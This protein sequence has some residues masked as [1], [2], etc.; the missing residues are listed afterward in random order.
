MSK[1]LHFNACPIIA[2]ARAAGEMYYYN[3]NPCK[4]GHLSKRVTSTQMCWECK[5][6]AQNARR[7][8]ERA[9]NP[10]GPTGKVKVLSAIQEGPRTTQDLVA[11]SGLVE[12]SVRV[13]ITNCRKKGHIISSYRGTH[14]YGDLPFKTVEELDKERKAEARAAGKKRYQPVEPCK[15]GH[16]AERY[17]DGTA[18]VECLANNTT[19]YIK[20]RPEHY[21][22]LASIRKMRPEER[23]KT[24]A[25][26]RKGRAENSSVG[27]ALRAG[28]TRARGKLRGRM[29]VLEDHLPADVAHLLAIKDGGTCPRCSTTSFDRAV[30]AYNKF[31]TG[32]TKTKASILSSIRLTLDHIVAVNNGGTND[33]SNLQI[34]CHRCNSVKQD[35]H[36]I[37]LIDGTIAYYRTQEQLE[38]ILAQ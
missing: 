10:R 6:I 38:R 37:C 29:T 14:Y 31:N 35:R 34:I 26:R 12:A 21:A 19:R 24:N 15:E 7:A 30:I 36:E 27:Q 25:R 23:K 2:A 28:D 18:C 22:R 9:Q 20:A 17:V 11:L 16:Y 3:G 32:V 13:V 4:H 1:E 5:N 8:K 33:V